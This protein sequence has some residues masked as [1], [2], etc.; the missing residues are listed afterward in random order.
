MARRTTNLSSE[1]LLEGYKNG[2]MDSFREFYQRTKGLIYNYLLKRMGRQV[3]ADE[4]FQETFLRLHRFVTSYE[5][6]QRALPWLFTIARNV[7]I[8][9][10]RKRRNDTDI[11]NL[12][13]P[14]SK[15]PLP[16]IALIAKQQLESIMSTLQAEDRDLLTARFVNEDSYEEIA[17]RT[18]LR[19]ENVRQRISRLARNLRNIL[20]Q[21]D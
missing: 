9:L 10:H 8:D 14:A 6:A 21:T 3:D 17:A 12:D 5:P 16:D 13:E 2:D 18:G 15:E 19:S 7:S 11:S 4:A 1:Q 20:R